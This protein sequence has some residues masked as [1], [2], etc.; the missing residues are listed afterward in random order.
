MKKIV[1]PVFRFSYGYLKQLADKT[2]L[3]MDRDKTEFLDRGFSATKKTAFADAIAR[4]A[5][6]PTDEQLESAKIE[7]TQSK[8][9][10]RMAFENSA[11][12]FYLAA[13]NT[14][15]TDSA[16]YRAFG[17]A[18]LSSQ[19]DADLVRNG[20]NIVSAATKYSAELAGEGITAKK[21]SDFET[22][23]K[24]FDEALDLQANHISERDNATELRATLANELYALVVKYSDTG[25]DIWAN[26]SEAHYNDYVIYNTLSG[27]K[28]DEN[29]TP[30][31]I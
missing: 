4:F 2:L 1:I 29:P 11:R 7:M 3:Q 20:K 24:K 13:K 26:K 23:R 15:G 10:I 21:V 6:F 27:Q 30:P 22:L 9:G 31:A 16:K 17:N 18:D 8:D 12:S 28:E 5:D 25:K 19:K 14:F